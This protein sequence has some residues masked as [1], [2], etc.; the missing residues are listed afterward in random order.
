[1]RR[2]PGPCVIANCTHTRLFCAIS[3]DSVMER[4]EWWR[5]INWKHSAQTRCAGTSDFGYEDQFIP[6]NSTSVHHGYWSEINRVSTTLADRSFRIELVRKR[7]DV[8]VERFSARRQN[9][10]LARL[11]DD[12]HLVA[13]QHARKSPTPMV[14]RRTFPYPRWP[15]TDCAIS[16]AAVCNRYGCG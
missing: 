14:A 1:M 7:H 9:K 13:L 10:A 3:N 11:R 4:T 6:M 16:R 2:S 5:E 12:L 8:R 15:T